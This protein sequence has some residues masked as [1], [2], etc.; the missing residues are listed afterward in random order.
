M[1]SRATPRTREELARIIETERSV[2]SSSLLPALYASSD[3]PVSRCGRRTP[4]ILNSSQET[5]V[6]LTESVTVIDTALNQWADT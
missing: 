3:A 1:L 2:V 4:S 5:L 6:R